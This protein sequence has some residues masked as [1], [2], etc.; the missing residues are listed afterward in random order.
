MNQLFSESDSEAR[1]VYKQINE[2][3]ICLGA[4]LEF[5]IGSRFIFQ[6][7]FFVGKSQS[8]LSDRQTSSDLNVESLMSNVSGTRYD[9]VPTLSY[10][11]LDSDIYLSLAFLYSVHN[12][13]I[14]QDPE[15][16]GEG[17][18][19]EGKFSLTSSQKAGF[20]LIS[21]SEPSFKNKQITLGSSLGIKIK[22]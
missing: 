21:S 17:I 18:N 3:F 4:N 5:K 9:L 12:Y 8:D 7:D 20:K 2:K 11:I 13:D 16:S 14:N 19:Q 1:R 6:T 22:L 10:K 15:I